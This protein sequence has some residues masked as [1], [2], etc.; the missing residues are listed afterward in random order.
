[1][2]WVLVN[3]PERRILVTGRP[4]DVDE[5]K[6]KGWDVAYEAEDWGD[7]YEVA[8]LLGEEEFVI[9]WYL[10]EELAATRPRKA[11]AQIGVS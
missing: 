5:L 7:A 10:E 4:S 11:A 6:E 9:E 3:L 1:M 8:L 2:Q